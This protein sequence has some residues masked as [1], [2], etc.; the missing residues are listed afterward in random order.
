MMHTLLPVA[1]VTLLWWSSTGAVLW[2]ANGR[3]EQ[4]HFRL[5]GITLTCAFGFAGLIVAS[6][7]DAAWSPYLAFISALAVWGWIEFTFLAGMVTGPHFG[8]CPPDAS[9]RQRFRLAFRTIMHHEFTLLAALI[10]IWAINHVSGNMMGFYTFAL[11]WLMRLSAK[12]TIFSGAPTLSIDM[13]PHRLAHM[14]TYFRVDRIGPVF[15]ASIVT[16]SVL[17]VA[18]IWCLM[19]EKISADAH[20]GLVML[21]T[22]VALAVLEHLFMVLPMRD[23]A[24]WGWAMSEENDKK[25]A[26]TAAE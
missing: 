2:L 10:G 5:L 7:S 22:L 11:L 17:L 9:E 26:A 14:K 16:N 25:A 3:T 23:S 6:T 8:D 1:F 18:A 20:V 15:W 4:L 21:T 24:L 12:L 13:M 19:N